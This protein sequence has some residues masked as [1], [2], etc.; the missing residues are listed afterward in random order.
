MDNETGLFII[1]AIRQEFI[2]IKNLAEDAFY[3][4]IRDHSLY[5]DVFRKEH[6]HNAEPVSI[7]II[8]QHITG[9]LRSRWTDF[10]TTDGEKSW[11]DRDREF[12]S[13]R[14]NNDELLEKWNEAWMLLFKAIV[15]ELEMKP[16]LLM[17]TIYI[18]KEPLTVYEAL[19][20]QITHHSYHA[21]QIVLIAKEIKGDS[22][23]TL[24]IPPGKSAEYLTKASKKRTQIKSAASIK[25]NKA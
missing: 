7:G 12:V 13:Q 25:Q 8:M 20:R 22:W 23:Q 14:L 17:K 11:R 15:E 19:I 2:K 9:N 5:M 10:L 3:Q 18:R 1:E 16:E 21:G 24:S 4:L 6:R